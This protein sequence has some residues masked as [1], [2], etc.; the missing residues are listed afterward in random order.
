MSESIS[1][2]LA[3]IILIIVLL[4]I[5]FPAIEDTLGV[6]AYSSLFKFS[7]ILLLFVLLMS[8]FRR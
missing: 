7:L 6:V 3:S 2:K 1:D 4:Y 5:I 8:L